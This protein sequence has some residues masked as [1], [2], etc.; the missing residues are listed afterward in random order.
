LKALKEEPPVKVDS[1]VNQAD[2]LALWGGTVFTKTE[3]DLL[4][5]APEGIVTRFDGVV[6][7]QH[8]AKGPLKEKKAFIP[9]VEDKEWLRRAVALALV[10]LPDVENNPRRQGLLLLPAGWKKQATIRNR[11]SE[12]FVVRYL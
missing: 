7:I 9:L 11:T 1:L 8:S 5:E 4:G 2:G 12:K 6:S 10:L 3:A